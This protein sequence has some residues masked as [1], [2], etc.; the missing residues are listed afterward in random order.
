MLKLLGATA[1]SVLV[2]GPA[3]ATAPHCHAQLSSI[4]G[5]MSENPGDASRLATTYGRAE[6]LCK[7]GREEQAQALAQDIRNDI[8]QSMSGV[9]SNGLASVGG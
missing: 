2:I 1:L 4:K 7:D 3:W 5:Y 9:A 8:A 6:R